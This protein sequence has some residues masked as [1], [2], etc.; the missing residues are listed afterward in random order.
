MKI[1]R[2][3]FLVVVSTAFGVAGLTLWAQP[4]PAETRGT[5]SRGAPAVRETV[6]AIQERQRKTPPQ[7]MEIENEVRR[8]E[9]RRGNPQN[10]AAKPGAEWPPRKAPPGRGQSALSVPALAQTVKPGSPSI[11]AA[12]TLGTSFTGATVLGV[13]STNATPPDSM[14]TVGP[15]Q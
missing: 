2:L 8:N 15:T 12:Q 7:P 11:Y 10:P 5:P 1:K 9:R 13:N 4:P 3:T 6:S 14:G